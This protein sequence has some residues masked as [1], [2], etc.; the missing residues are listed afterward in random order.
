MWLGRFRLLQRSRWAASTWP[1][2]L[3]Q[4]NLG[5]NAL[6]DS[7]GTRWR[8][9]VG[10]GWLGG[11]LAGLLVGCVVGW[12]VGLPVAVVPSGVALRKLKNK[13]IP[14]STQHI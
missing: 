8:R 6:I 14:R 12:L 9:I 11:W 2:G 1:R 3:A 5:F 13:R 7:G 4:R 10:V